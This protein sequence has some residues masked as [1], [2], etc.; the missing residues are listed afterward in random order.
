MAEDTEQQATRFSHLARIPGN[1]LGKALVHRL[2]EA[3]DAV[4]NSAVDRARFVDVSPQDRRAERAVL[5]DHLVE[6]EALGESMLR[7]RLGG[8]GHLR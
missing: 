6:R 4:Q 5:R 1:R 2:T 7:V 3:D 8:P